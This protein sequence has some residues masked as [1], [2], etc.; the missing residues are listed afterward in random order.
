MINSLFWLNCQLS[1]LSSALKPLPNKSNYLCGS[2]LAALLGSSYRWVHHFLAL[3]FVCDSF[4]V[5]LEEESLLYSFA[6]REEGDAGTWSVIPED[7]MFSCLPP[8][9]PLWAL[10][11]FCGAMIV[12]CIQCWVSPT[13]WGTPASFPCPLPPSEML[14]RKCLS[15]TQ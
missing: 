9:P 2:W 13:L 11:H 12:G 8:N 3:L 6:N 4:S 14:Q 5:G 1:F 15:S 7:S 10:S